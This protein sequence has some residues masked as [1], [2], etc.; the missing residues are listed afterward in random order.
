MSWV[1]RVARV[2]EKINAYRVL[3]GKH[4]GNKPQEDINV[5]GTIILKHILEKWDWKYGFDSSGSGE[6]PVGGFCEHGNDPSGSMKF[7][8]FLVSE[9]LVASHVALGSE[10]LLG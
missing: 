3:V 5:Y 4:E 8:N 10:K 2:G 9:E 1:R 6:G 7:R